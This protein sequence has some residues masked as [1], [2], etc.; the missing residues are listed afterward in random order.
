MNITRETFFLK[1]HTQNVTEKLFPD[2][3]LKNRNWVYLLINS[4]IVLYRFFFIV[5]KFKVYWNIVKASCRPFAFT[6]HNAFLKTEKRS[7]TCHFDLFS[8]WFWSKIFFLLYSINWPNLLVWLPLIWEILSNTCIVIVCQPNCDV[9]NFK[10]NLIFL[11]KPFFLHDQKV[12]T[13]I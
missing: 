12:K 1:D 6:L 9:M 8:A 2:P 11:I 4:R 13:K 5:C 7:G 10:I 3:F